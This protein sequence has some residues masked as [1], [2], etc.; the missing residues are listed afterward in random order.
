[1][2]RRKKSNASTGGCVALFVLGIA[3][4][5]FSYLSTHP[6]VGVLI[7]FGIAVAGVLHIFWPIMTGTP[8]DGDVAKPSSTRIT[9]G[10]LAA[11]VGVV[12]A[13][14]YCSTWIDNVREAKQQRLAAAE[15]ERERISKCEVMGGLLAVMS[16][17]AETN[18]ESIVQVSQGWEDCPDLTTSDKQVVAQAHV[19]LG[20]R[21][22]DCNAALRQHFEE[23]LKLVPGHTEATDAKVACVN[24]LAATARQEGKTHLHAGEYKDAIADYQ[25]PQGHGRC[26]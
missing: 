23:A 5:G 4:C 11:I 2:A 10:V 16:A 14:A 17:E 22:E 1:M 7:G 18:T 25:V 8:K 26:P 3:V 19:T 9:R 21:M 6:H 15:A 13:G 12:M 24:E 20:S